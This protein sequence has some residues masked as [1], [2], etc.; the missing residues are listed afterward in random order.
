MAALNTNTQPASAAAPSHSQAAVAVDG[1]P[2]QTLV[3]KITALTL[4]APPLALAHTDLVIEPSPWEYD[5]CLVGNF[6]T[7]K[8]MNL[9]PIRRSLPSIWEPGRGVKV[10]E[11]DGGLYMFHF[12]HQLDVRNVMNKRP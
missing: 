11:L 12:E 7:K 9:Q 8:E 6:L 1:R 3:E 4:A 10:D 2:E 5:L